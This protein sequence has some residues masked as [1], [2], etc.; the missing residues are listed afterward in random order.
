M[1]NQKT[2]LRIIFASL[3]F[4]IMKIVDWPQTERPREKLAQLGAAHLSDA[5]LLAVLLGTGNQEHNALE[6]SHHLQNHFGGLRGIFSASFS[7]FTEYCGLG[8]AK[9]ARLQ[10][11]LELSRRHLQEEI[12]HHGPIKA[13]KDVKSFLL[14]SLRKHSNEVFACFFLNRQHQLIAFEELFRG[15]LTYTSIHPREFIKRALHHNA[16]AVMLAH[17]H[18]SGDPTPSVAD[19]SVTDT[20]QH[21]LALIEIKLLDHLI[22]GGTALYSV[23]GECLV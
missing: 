9:Y 12:M 15:T 5:E 20:L 16:A 14:A 22:V 17:N 23:M 11:G 10:A 2:V 4:I 1:S 6:L 19:R 18:P 13:A 21:C 8:L 3:I 7:E